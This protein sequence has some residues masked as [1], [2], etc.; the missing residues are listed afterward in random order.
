M[1]RKTDCDRSTNAPASSPCAMHEVDPAYMGLADNQEHPRGPR[2]ELLGDLGNALLA[3]LPDAIIYADREG[4]IRFWNRGAER[5]FG[6]S[7]EE[8]LG[9]SLDIIIPER[10]QKRHWDGYA[11][12]METGESRH[13]ADD[14]LAV[15]ALNK[16]GEK[17]SIQ[18]TVAPVIGQDRALAGIVSLSRDVTETFEEMRRLRANQ[19]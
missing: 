1:T 4:A 15:P 6:F 12:M 2:G 17:L 8:A 9:Q 7:A 5:I 13:A 19:S 3:G 10:L 18:F 11:R 14:M 16:A